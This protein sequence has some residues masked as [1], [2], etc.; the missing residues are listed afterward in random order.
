MGEQEIFAVA[1]VIDAGRVQEEKVGS[2]ARPLR[3]WNRGR[4]PALGRLEC[5]L[6]QVNLALLG[7][8]NRLHLSA[9]LLLRFIQYGKVPQFSTRTLVR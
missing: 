6:C 5:W 4:M 1:E 8:A 3:L 9:P 2:K 7:Y